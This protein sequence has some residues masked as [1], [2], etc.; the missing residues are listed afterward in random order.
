MCE[1]GESVWVRKTKTGIECVTWVNVNLLAG[2]AV[3]RGKTCDKSKRVVE[4]GGDVSACAPHVI[5]ECWT[6][7]DVILDVDEANQHLRGA[8]KQ[9]S[10]KD[11]LKMDLQGLELQ[12]WLGTEAGRLGR[13]DFPR[14]TLAG[15]WRLKDQVI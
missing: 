2:H 12:F 13:Y 6:H 8:W 10:N 1:G 9:E 3:S 14:E 5:M 11:D 4:T 7:H 15:E